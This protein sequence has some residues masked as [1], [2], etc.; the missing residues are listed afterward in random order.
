MFEPVTKPRDYQLAAVKW[1]AKREHGMLLMDTRT[2]KTKTTIDWLS[3]LMHNRDVRYIVV[4]C[5]KIA[6]DVW[7]RE[8]Q[9]HYWGP[10]ADIVYDGAYEATAP[11]K[12]VLINYDKFSRGYP[13]GLF[14]GAEYHASAIVLD[15][16]HLIKTPACKRSRRIVGMAKS[17]R[18][19]VC[20][21]AT[22]VGKRNMVGEIYP[23]LVFSD[24]SIRSDFP[25]AKS[26]REYFGEWSNFGG[27]PRYIGPRNTNEYQALIKAHSIS[28]SR[29]DALG[30]KAVQEDVVPVYMDESHHAT[31]QAM[32]RDE[33]DILEAQGETG[34]DSVLALFAKCRRL[35]E[36]LSTGEGKLIHSTHKLEA[37]LRIRDSY[38]GRIVVASELLDSLTV[39]EGHL[40]P[41]YRLDGKVKDKT[42][43]LDAWKDSEAGTLIV[44]PQVAATAVDMREAEVLVWYGV[45]TSA[46][47]YRQ[48]SDR[49]A[50]ASDPKVIVLVTQDTVEDSLW[51]S[52]AEATEFRKEIMMN[53]RDF[54]LG[55]TYVSE[56]V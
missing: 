22:P 48:M 54:L 47:T 20:L 27:F 14:K 19:R 43:V 42:T 17:A 44:N 49:V 3:W 53:T 45:P 34:A 25:S 55:E 38:S 10:E 35:A 37:L 6:I 32:V 33:L 8:L 12:I 52:L 46:L 1:L 21:T 31:Y 18:Y 40:D 23:Q 50:L 30:T 11:P 26:F 51:S 56:S 24:P 4:V 41:T 9:Q 39:L 28:I 15:E 7:V 2:G 13:K 5:P 29:K 36:G 16:S